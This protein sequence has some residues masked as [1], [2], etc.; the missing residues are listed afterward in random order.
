MIRANAFL[1]ALK[2]TK[3]MGLTFKPLN[4]QG[5]GIMVVCDASLGNVRKEGD[6]GGHATERVYSQ[7]CYMVCL[8]GKEGDFCVLDGRPHRLTRVCRS[9]FSAELLDMEEATDAGHFTRGFLAS[10]LGYPLNCRNIEASLQA[11]PLCV[12]TDAKDVFDESSS[13]APM[14][15]RNL[16]HIP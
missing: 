4:L 16:W 12:V 2:D 9:T 15:L 5:A 10:V 14:E 11:I 8:S 1:R 13:S 3:Q 6:C 7:A